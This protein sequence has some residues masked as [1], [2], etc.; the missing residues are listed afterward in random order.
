M[1]K[2]IQN[3]RDC[4]GCGVCAV[5]CPTNA[6][7]ISLNPNGF[8]EPNLD[9]SKCINCGLCVLS[10]SY[11]DDSLSLEK[12]RELKS[13]A[14]WSNNERVRY[15]CSSGGIGFE[16]G[17][18][19]IEKG[20]KACGVCYNAGTNRAEHYIATTAKEYIPSIGSKYIQSYTLN[21]FSQFKKK[22][23]YLVTGTPCQIDSLRKYFRLKRMEDNVVLMDFFCHGVPSMLLWDKY[24]KQVE[25]VVGKV[26][27]VSWRSKQT[28]WH[29]SWVM[30]IDGEKHS[31]TID[32][33]ES[34]S[35]LSNEKEPF[36][37]SRSSQGDPFYRMFLG[38]VCLGKACYEKCKYKYDQSAADIRIGDLWG[39]L[40]K[41]NDKG[42][43]AL[44][45]FT[46][47]GNKVLENLMEC[48]LIEHPF[49]I[50]A[51]GQMKDMPIT[52][53]TYNVVKRMLKF[54]FSIS[55]IFFV[56]HF[57]TQIFYKLRTILRKLK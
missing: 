16:I 21:A 25:E 14:A 33:V 56:H 43:S 36:F 48:T 44:V 23:K 29:D 38:D 17:K 3:V 52:P 18:Q 35:L 39:H 57:S 13:Y 2:S 28:G 8:Y 20:Y 51:E 42:V 31:Q 32:Q 27:Y 24:L 41:D 49:E 50:V 53:I 54:N 26:N 30:G 37:C 15:R 4:Y 45:S 9:E 22:E 10:C 12:P 5:V 46:D 7:E 47:K 19:L 55:F 40:Y 6:I 34:T 11:L 1:N